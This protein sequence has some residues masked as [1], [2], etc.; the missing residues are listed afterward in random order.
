MDTSPAPGSSV[1]A[2]VRFGAGPWH[3]ETNVTVPS[4]PTR[5][6]QMLPMVQDL[7]DSMVSAVCQDV[8][9][10]GQ[11][12]SCKKGCGACCRQMVPISQVE[13]RAIRD[14]VD[15]LPE[16]RRSEIRTRFA[17]ACRRLSD[18]G[19]LEKVRRR[20]QWTDEDYKSTSDAYFSQR[21]A[22]PFLEEESCS[23]HPDRP[24]SCREYLVTSPPEHCAQ[25]RGGK[26][27]VL[28]LPFRLWW[29]L[30][31]FDR[32]PDDARYV[33][34]VPLVLALEWVGEHPDEEI[35]RPGPELVAQLFEK[36][37][38]REGQALPPPSA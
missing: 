2:T 25:P 3:M 10:H 26:V 19:L 32:P 11:S 37:A 1:T 38:G 36:L 23:I 15:R 22:C 8:E 17:D 33:A 4:G 13:A 16:P 14:L 34:W 35:P 24:I 7:S 6:R 5:L 31:R 28:P 9:K 18:Q 30:A 20:D 29:G 27:Q 12:V 21:I